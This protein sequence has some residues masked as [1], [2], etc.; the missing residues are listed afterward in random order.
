MTKNLNPIEESEYWENFSTPFLSYLGSSIIER[1]HVA[2]DIKMRK[3]EDV[4]LVDKFGLSVDAVFA[5]LN[6]K[7]IEFFAK[8]APLEYKKEMASIFSDQEMMDGVWEIVR[9]M[10]N[11]EGDG[12]TENQD[13]IKRVVQYIQDNRIAFQL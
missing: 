9:A 2:G 6:E 11:D 13:R 10:D 5:G 1:K 3:P 8:N 4:L 7:Q 12:S